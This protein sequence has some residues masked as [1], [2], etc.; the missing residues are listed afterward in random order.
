[1]R[2]LDR[3]KKYN[4]EH[5]T[6]EQLGQLFD[7]I[8][9][10]NSWWDNKEY[11]VENQ[12]K[13]YNIGYEDSGWRLVRKDEGS[14]DARELFNGWYKTDDPM[15]EGWLAY[16]DYTKNI[17]WG[18]NWEG[19]WFKVDYTE[20]IPMDKTYFAHLSKV[21]D[22]LK[23]EAERRGYKGKFTFDL[24]ELMCDGVTILKDG[25]WGT[26]GTYQF[27]G[28]NLFCSN[29][30]CYTIGVDTYKKEEVFYYHNSEKHGAN[31]Y[32]IIKEIQTKVGSEWKT[33]VIYKQLG[34]G[35]EFS[36]E[37]EEFY[38]K[39]KKVSIEK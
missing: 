19:V 27:F 16:V 33:F 24:N 39:F 26:V 12:Y 25:E 22:T 21:Y 7:E 17:I 38:N 29:D 4:L 2:K 35:L 13:R 15:N 31:F 34:S 14:T 10:E 20:E 5:L 3:S 8:A 37:K 6:P 32:D 28:D 23:E 18:F 36:R 9:K 1:M 11:F 30:G